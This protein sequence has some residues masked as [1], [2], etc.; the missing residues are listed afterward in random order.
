MRRT[1]SGRQVLAAILVS[2]ALAPGRAGA[3]SGTSI[4]Q[5]TVVTSTGKRPV[6]EAVVTVSSPDLQVQQIVVTDSSGFYRVPNLPPG[7]YLLRVDKDSFLPHERAG[8]AVRGDITL[9]VNID[10]IP[11]ASRAEETVV[12]V[13]PPNIDL[14]SSSVTT[15]VNEEMVRR[16]PIARPGTKG[17]GVRSFESVADAAPQAR[18]DFYGT[19]VS[20]TTSPENRY[21]IDGLSVNNPTFAI[22]GS[23]LSSEF[24]RQVDVSTGGYMPEFGRST[25]GVISA[26]TKSGSNEIR[27]SAWSFATP[28]FLEATPNTVVDTGNTIR[29]DRPRTDLIFDTGADIGFP[30]VKDKLWAYGGF[31]YSRSNYTLRRSLW[32]TELGPDGTPIVDN[33]TVRQREIPGS[34]SSFPESATQIQGLIKLS[35][36]PNADHSFSLTSVATP[37][38]SGGGGAYPL[39]PQTGR[40]VRNVAG[41][42]EGI[43]QQFKDD[44]FDQ[45]VKWTAST[46]GKRVTFETTLGWHHEVNDRLPSDGSLP[47]S[48]RGLA[49]IS[50]VEYLQSD[51][52]VHSIT[53][54]ESVPMGYCEGPNAADR[55]PV[56][57]YNSTSVGYIQQ[58]SSDRYQLRSVASWLAQGL[59]HHVLKLGVDG[60]YVGFNVTKAYAGG[61]FY[62]ETDDGT[63][64]TEFRNYGYLLGPEDPVSRPT[65]HSNTSTFLIGGFLQDSWSILDK[66]TLNAGLR[67]DTQSLYNTQKELGLTLPNQISPRVGV[68][69]DPTQE[70]R[71][72]LFANVA[73]YTQFVPLDLADR[74]LAGESQIVAQRAKSLCNPSDPV[75]AKGSCRS[76]DSLVDL[77]P[78]FDP[79]TKWGQTG[80]ASTP[81]D[82]AIKPNSTDELVVG[83]EYQVLRE[84]RVGLTYSRRRMNEIIEDMSRD[85]ARTYFIGNPGR[86]IAA[87][88]PRARRDY[89]AFTAYFTR[90]WY[91]HWLAQASYTLSWLYGNWSGLFRPETNQLDP[92]INADFDLQSLLPNRTG[93]LPG[94]RRHQIKVFGARELIVGRNHVFQGG[95]GVRAASGAP[96]DYLGAHAIYG[97]D[98]VSILQ[99]GSGKRLPWTYSADVTL[100]YGFAASRAYSITGTVTCFNVFNLQMATQTDQTY[101]RSNVLPVIG[102]T[103]PADLAKITTP[104]GKMF[105]ADN[106]NPNFGNPQQYQAPRI[107][108][109]GLR[110]TY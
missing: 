70:G 21:L 110:V 103:S 56:S 71:A 46:P 94:D 29:G 58:A 81:I 13:R 16:V 90:S 7:Q 104:T 80:G 27:G 83:G 60:E 82:P 92:G 84:S 76:P 1:N 8:I 38:R 97:V 36:S 55:C 12:I 74:S 47:G 61:V 45:Q 106:V 33:G 102:G 86:G 62:Q 34:R 88:F 101:T 24:L 54:F 75:M 31:Q 108:Q 68:I 37:F 50:G 85:E 11:E 5:G 48:G 35:Y 39:D 42:Y 57:D 65:F 99:R 73:R 53:D 43:A 67:Y 79:H 26:T 4:L 105:V 96:T 89:D 40:P 98:E 49:N 91:E 72:K 10:L 18:G 52:T 41:T 9:R 77:G 100:S 6:A 28:G 14:G 87:G 59:G 109:F 78:P 66:V 25:G 93:Y 23:S 17:A 64:F 107:F 30:I 95:L 19:G 20:G 15:T 44:A 69:W 22:S 51:P 2:A 3:Q 32:E 63:G